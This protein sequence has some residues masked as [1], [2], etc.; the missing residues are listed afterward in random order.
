MSPWHDFV[1]R[2]PRVEALAGRLRTLL[3]PLNFITIHYAYFIGLGLV[4]SLVFWGSSSPAAS[5]SYVDSL[6]LV[7]S[8]MTEAGLN[9]VNLSDM[10]TWQQTMLF[11]LILLGSS[12]WVSIWT[13]LFRRHVFE[14]RFE[15]IVLAERARSARRPRPASSSRFLGITESLSFRK[16][17]AALPP[18]L[19]AMGSKIITRPPPPAEKQD[20][21]P[22]ALSDT[23]AGGGAD[24]G[25]A[26]GAV[27]EIGPAGGAAAP[28]HVV[29]AEESHPPHITGS[30][31]STST[32][33]QPET[34]PVRRAAAKD[35]PPAAPASEF[36]SDR[37][38][39][40]NAQFHDL[41]RDER[42][43]LG[44][45]EYRA[46]KILSVI[47]PLYFFLWQFLGCIALGAWINHK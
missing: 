7:V 12:I 15:A 9:T 44:G 31:E 6:F 46:L 27:D 22:A 14:K 4:A 20:A 8:A 33:Y 23:P 42:E 47:V 35:G 16:N 34:R 32:A 17:P 43:R 3:P 11:L 24:D 13:V 18:P 40:R 10:T 36:L 28:A 37:M 2:Y 41:T 45:Y 5:I 29:F 1:D 30:G 19:P 38:V 39:G 21:P 25:A 26:A